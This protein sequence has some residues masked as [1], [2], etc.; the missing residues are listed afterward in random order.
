MYV[1][2]LLLA[3]LTPQTVPL[4]GMGAD[5]PKPL[6]E[7]H[8]MADIKTEWIA[9]S[10]A[11]LTAEELAL[12]TTGADATS[13]PSK[14]DMPAALADRLVIEAG[15]LGGVVAEAHVGHNKRHYREHL[16]KA[17]RQSRQMAYWLRL[18]AA[19]EVIPSEVLS[20]FLENNQILHET[21]TG[22]CAAAQNDKAADKS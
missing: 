18:V 7:V 17:R 16:N 2:T 12:R 4:P 22:L 20:P 13:D 21:L 6:P 15:E 19:A 10:K 9:P 14:D 5:A 3:A 11:P 1:T 8:D